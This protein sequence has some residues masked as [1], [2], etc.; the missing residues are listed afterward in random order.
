MKIKPSLLL[1]VLLLAISAAGQTTSHFDGQTWWDHVKVLADDK[2]EGRE[3]GSDG[4]RA[5][6][7]LRGRA[8]EARGRCSRPAPTVSTSR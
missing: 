1:L 4:V 8:A 3:T 5:A 2:L 7:S 6:A